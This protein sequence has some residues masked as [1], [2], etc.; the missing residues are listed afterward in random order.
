MILNVWNGRVYEA[1]FVIVNSSITSQY[2][3][4]FFFI[5]L[6]LL[7]CITTLRFYELLQIVSTT[8]T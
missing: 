4:F 8:T 1:I 3:V 6:E 7:F 2:S 5:P